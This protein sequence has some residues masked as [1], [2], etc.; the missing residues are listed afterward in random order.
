MS[1]LQRSSPVR[2]KRSCWSVRAALTPPRKHTG[3]PSSMRRVS[4]MYFQ[5]DTHSCAAMIC[6]VGFA[7]GME[8]VGVRRNNQ[9]GNH[10]QL[11]SCTAW[12]ARGQV[13]PERGLAHPFSSPPSFLSRS[14]MRTP[15]P[16]PQSN[17]R[18]EGRATKARATFFFLEQQRERYQKKTFKDVQR[19]GFTDGSLWSPREVIYFQ[20][21]ATQREDALFFP[22]HEPSKISLG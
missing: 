12:L 10:S 4:I 13:S 18:E 20:Q 1:G 17:R 11:C 22:P 14:L 7:L 19:A 15:S 3:V 9:Q 5:S 2:V 8:G 16:T 21:G 6:R